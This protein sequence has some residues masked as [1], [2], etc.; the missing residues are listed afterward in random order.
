MSSIDINP[1]SETSNLDSSNK[2]RG[3]L[4]IAS[5]NTAPVFESKERIF[6][7]VSEFA[8]VLVMFPLHPAIPFG[9]GNRT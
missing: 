1:D 7:E 9:A 4:A 2:R 5:G 6:D 8:E 3:V